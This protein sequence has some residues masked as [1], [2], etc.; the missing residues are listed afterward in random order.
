[1]SKKRDSKEIQQIVDLYTKKNPKILTRGQ[2]KQSTLDKIMEDI[3]ARQKKK[4]GN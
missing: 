1:M 4:N 2:I 3:N